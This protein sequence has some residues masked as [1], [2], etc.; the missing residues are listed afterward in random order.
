MKIILHCG[1]HKTG[2]TF[3]QKSVFRKLD[4]QRDKILYNP[5]NF[6]HL[7]IECINYRKNNKTLSEELLDLVRKC[8]KEMESRHDPEYVFCSFEPLGRDVSEM[9]TCFR[10]KILKEIIPDASV[11]FFLRFQSDWL[12]SLY[13]QHIHHASNPYIKQIGKNRI[14]SNNKMITFKQFINWDDENKT[15]GEFNPELPYSNMGVHDIDW[16]VIIDSLYDNFGEEKTHIFFYEKFRESPELFVNEF[17]MFIF[18]YK[19]NIINDVD[20]SKRYNEGYSSVALKLTELK[21]NILTF[22]YL[23]INIARTIDTWLGEL[24]GYFTKSSMILF[25][26]K[27]MQ[28]VRAYLKK[29]VMLFSWLNIMHSFDKCFESKTSIVDPVLRKKLEDEYVVLNNRFQKNHDELLIPTKY[30]KTI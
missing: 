26:P 25:L 22:P 16:C 8:L 17:F 20:Y 19:P 30:Y 18:G 15:F 28:K 11:V 24:E 1:L 10:I 23:H 7:L 3:L 14:L 2:T 4:V 9:D 13:K 27:Y 12:I 6:I 29:F 21:I 5:N